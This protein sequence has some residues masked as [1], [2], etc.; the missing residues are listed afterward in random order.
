MA[1]ADWKAGEP[2]TLLDA[3]SMNPYFLTD[4]FEDEDMFQRE[5]KAMKRFGRIDI[6]PNTI[7]VVYGCRGGKITMRFFGFTLKDWYV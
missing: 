7:D 5:L 3:D 6:P 4:L 2:M 1:E